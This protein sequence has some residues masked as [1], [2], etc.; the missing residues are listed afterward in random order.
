MRR[1]DVTAQQLR[2]LD[3]ETATEAP[4]VTDPLA[5]YPEWLMSEFGLVEN[6]VGTHRRYAGAMLRESGKASL[7]EFLSDPAAVV[8]AIK[9]AKQSDTRH[10]RHT[11]VREL[12]DHARGRLSGP[13]IDEAFPPSSP[14]FRVAF[15]TTCI[16]STS[17]WAVIPN[18]LARLGPTHWRS[19]MP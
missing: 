13:M 16:S 18:D 19:W 7:D 15:E 1:R 9:R 4:E 8:A 12:L 3:A 6:T 17:T 5:N 2:L 11:V 14:A 10:Q